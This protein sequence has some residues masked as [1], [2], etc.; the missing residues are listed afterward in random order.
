MST[1]HFTLIVD[2]PDVQSDAVI[3]ALYEAGCDDALIGQTDGIQYVEFDRE[4][5]GVVE[6]VSSAVAD[7]ERVEGVRVV[8]IADAGLVSMA[9]IA[10]RTGRNAGRGATAGNGG[11]GSG[12]LSAAGYRSARPVQALALVGCGTLAGGEPRRGCGDGGG[13]RAGRHQRQPGAPPSWTPAGCRSAGHPAETGGAVAGR[14]SGTRS[15]RRTLDVAVL[16]TGSFL[17]V[18]V[19][20][21]LRTAGAPARPTGREPALPDPPPGAPRGRRPTRRRASAPMRGR[22]EPSAALTRARFFISIP[23]IRCPW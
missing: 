1:H 13:S 11:A 16:R 17:W 20:G 21:R 8:R 12:G 2:G 10:V 14:E 23:M 6:A 5:S 7:L 4:A 19:R 9:D 15:E 3:D 22:P 18:S